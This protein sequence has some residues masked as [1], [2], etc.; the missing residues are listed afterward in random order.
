MEFAEGLQQ[1]EL[2]VLSSA[3]YNEMYLGDGAAAALPAL[4]QWLQEQPAERLSAK[5]RRGR[6]PV[7]P[8]G[9]HLRGLRP[10]GRRGA[11]D[12]LRHRAARAALGGMD[13]AGNRLEAAR[14]GVERIHS[15]HLSR[16]ADLEGGR[17]SPPNRCSATRNTVRRCKAWMSLAAST[18]TSPASTSCAMMPGSSACWRTT[19]ACPRASPTCSRTAR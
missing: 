17:R 11:P 15:R 3:P 12:S 13:A 18:R 6:C 1:G 14:P 10:G 8:G 19:C 2:G 4:H 5:T 9:Y 16:A 7:P